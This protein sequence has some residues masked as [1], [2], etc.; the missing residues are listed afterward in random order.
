MGPPKPGQLSR[1]K[2]GPTQS[3]KPWK[4]QPRE[5]SVKDPAQL[6]WFCTRTKTVVSYNSTHQGFILVFCNFVREEIGVRRL[7]YNKK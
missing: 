6:Q 2:M 7:R 3:Q 5:K 1:M 4:Q